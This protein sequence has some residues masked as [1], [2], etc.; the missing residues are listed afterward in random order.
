MVNVNLSGLELLH[1]YGRYQQVDLIQAL[2]C[3]P[4][5]KS[6]II[7]NGSDLDADFLGEFVLMHLNETAVS[8]QSHDEGQIS[9]VL[10][11]MLRSLRIEDRDLKIRL[12]LIHVYKRVVTLRAVCGS[13]LESFTL[14]YFEL[15]RTIELV[16]SHGSFV[17]TIVLGGDA[18]PFRLDI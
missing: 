8:I 7:G 12:E 3:L 4:A 1:V 11:P 6:L 9:A 15:G 18:E 13:P 5:L 14:F 10:C 2:Q 16:G 17:E